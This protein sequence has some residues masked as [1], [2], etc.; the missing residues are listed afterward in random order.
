MAE[1]RVERPLWD[2]QPRR[3]LLHAGDGRD[4][5]GERAANAVFLLERRAQ[6]LHTYVLE[7]LLHGVPYISV[8]SLEPFLHFTVLL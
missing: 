1:S 3:T 7:C 4:R 5:T 6:S 8:R 2:S